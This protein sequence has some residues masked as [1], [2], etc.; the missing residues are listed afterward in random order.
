[1]KWLSFAR[2][3]RPSWGAATAGG[4]VD[5]GARRPELPTLRSAL[6]AGALAALAEQSAALSP[7]AA[8]GELALL[9]PV[10][11][12]QKI[13]CIGVNYADRPDEYRADATAPPRPAPRYPSVFMRSRESLVG[14]GQPLCIPL[15]SAQL[16]YEGEIAIVIGR[17]GRR[18]APERAREHIAGLTIMNEGSLRD[19]LRH[20]QFNVTPGK[21]FERSGSLG[22]WLV[23]ADELDPLGAL[24]VRT[25]V[26]GE[27]RQDDTTEHLLFPFAYLLHYLS[28]FFRLQPGD[29][30]ATGTPSGAGARFEPPRYLR[31]GDRVEVEVDG[32]GVLHNPVASEAEPLA[33]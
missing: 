3:G 12:P 25:R 7:D 14:C 16:D 26:N 8:L 4:V 33:A 17:E 31:P 19:Y 10:P 22:P 21:N 29:V 11:D 18:I 1:M 20:G 9:P 28:S 23:S 24:R 2:G 30:I 15:E 13:I 32:I 27:L 6:R 5:W